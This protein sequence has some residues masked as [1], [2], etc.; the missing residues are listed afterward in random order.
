MRNASYMP[1]WEKKV[2]AYINAY[3]VKMEKGMRIEENGKLL[4][5]NDGV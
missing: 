2:E 4:C 3:Y 1:V 5:F